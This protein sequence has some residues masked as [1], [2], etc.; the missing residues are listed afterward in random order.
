[1]MRGQYR[2]EV[3][4]TQVI[5]SFV[6]MQKTRLTVNVNKSNEYLINSLCEPGKFPP[7]NLEKSVQ[8]Q[9]N[10]QNIYDLAFRIISNT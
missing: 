3:H 10:I 8:V 2:Y 9:L 5:H 1:M 4:I 7:N 6:I